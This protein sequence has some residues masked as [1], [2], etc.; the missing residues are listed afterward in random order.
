MAELETALRQL[1]G[2]VAFPPTPDLASAIRPRLERPRPWRRPLAIALAVAVVAAIAAVLAVPQSR[3]AVLDWLGLRNLSVVRVDNLPRV[4]ATGRLHLGRE[5]T[6]AEAKRRAPWLL[7]PD[8]KPDSVYVSNSLPGGQ[9]SLVWG[10][11]ANVRLL[12]TEFSGQS[13]LE[14]VVQSDTTVE[15]V[16]IGNGGAWF[17]GPHIVMFQDRNGIFRESH[18]RLA[19]STLVWQVG[20]VTLRLE[21]HLTKDE[22]VRIARTTS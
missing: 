11:P 22:A 18:A 16:Q 21:G 14:K 19:G 20:D 12:L 3:S 13:Y 10:T 5:V 6:L 4:P 2:E 17:Q 7:V 15:R 1:G 9:V 8:S